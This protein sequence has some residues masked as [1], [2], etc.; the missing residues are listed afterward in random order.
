VHVGIPAR[1]TGKTK[2]KLELPDNIPKIDD[3]Y[4]D[5]V[6]STFLLCGTHEDLLDAMILI[7][8]DHEKQ[9][10]TIISIPRD[11]CY[12]NLKINY[13]YRKYGIDR[14]L[15]DLSWITGIRI[16]HYLMIDMFAFIEVIDIIG[17][18]DVILDKDLVDPTYKTRDCARWSYLSYKKG[19]HHLSGVQALRVA[20]SRHYTSDFDRAGRQQKIVEALNEKLKSLSI[21]DMKKIYD[22]IQTL[23][24]YV[25][26]NLSPLEFV[27]HFARLKNYGVDSQNVLDKSNV[28]RSSYYY[29]WLRNG[30]GSENTVSREN[31]KNKQDEQS[32]L[33]PYILIPRNDDWNLIRWYIRVV[34]LSVSE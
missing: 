2:K 13:T 28:L 11:L 16:Q 27:A 8:A 15:E 19:M 14:L 6:C 20:R 4:E 12:R 23:V 21:V 30:R 1:G 7:V 9:K 10:M 18:I 33:G 17:G 26:T 31:E 29:V 24:K 5:P 3:I 22:L 25:K 32:K 34:L